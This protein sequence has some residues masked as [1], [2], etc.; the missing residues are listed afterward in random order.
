MTHASSR[1]SRRPGRACAQGK[2]FAWRMW[3]EAVFRSDLTGVAV[4]V[5]SESGALLLLLQVVFSVRLFADQSEVRPR[6]LDG[7]GFPGEPDRWDLDA[8][9]ELA[10]RLPATESELLAGIVDHHRFV[11]RDP[12]HG[13]VHRGGKAFRVGR[14]PTRLI[15]DLDARQPQGRRPAVSRNIEPALRYVHH[16]VQSARPEWGVKVVHLVVGDRLSPEERESEVRPRSAARPPLR[17]PAL[18]LHER[19]VRRPRA[20]GEPVAGAVDARSDEFGGAGDA[21][22]E[23]VD[24]GWLQPRPRLVMAAVLV[25]PRNRVRLVAAAHRRLDGSAALGGRCRGAPGERRSANRGRGE[26]CP[27]EQ[28][29][30]PCAPRLVIAFHADLLWAVVSP[31]N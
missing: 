1:A 30:P 4:T 16:P 28:G 14:W 13:D 26:R 19:V 3:S 8:R 11:G 6:G 21:T 15:D 9:F 20:E 25:Q 10:A 24:A 2:A 29:T 7:V 12:A 27:A 23:V 22:L 5:T 18:A 17:G 31:Q